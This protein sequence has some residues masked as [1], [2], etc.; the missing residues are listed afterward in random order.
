MPNVTVVFVEI[1]NS[2]L[3]IFGFVYGCKINLHFPGVDEHMCK[4]K[5]EI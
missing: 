3:F 5:A 4:E 2:P 1:R